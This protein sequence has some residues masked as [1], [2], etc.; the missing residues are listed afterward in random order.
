MRNVSVGPRGS[1][2]IRCAIS[3]ERKISYHIDMCLTL[4]KDDHMSHTKRTSNVHKI[5]ENVSFQ[6]LFRINEKKKTWNLLTRSFDAVF[7][8]KTP[9]KSPMR[10]F[11][12]R[13]ILPLCNTK[14]WGVPSGSSSATWSENDH[15][16]TMSVESVKQFT[17][18]LNNMGKQ[19]SFREYLGHACAS[20]CVFPFA[21]VQNGSHNSD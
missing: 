20:S 3:R 5:L 13:V 1:R 2:P 8:L 15:K 17:I 14:D 18:T 11:T 16:A 6:H 7:G 9:L 21:H 12:S 10:E 19:R 4:R